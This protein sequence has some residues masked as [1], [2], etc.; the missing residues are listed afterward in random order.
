REPKID[1]LLRHQGW[2]NDNKTA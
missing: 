2:T 1:A